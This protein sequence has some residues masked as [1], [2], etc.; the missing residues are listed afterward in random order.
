MTLLQQ[1]Q[2]LAPLASA[3]TAAPWHIVEDNDGVNAAYYI[4]PQAGGYT[5]SEGEYNDLAT[6]SDHSNAAYI[7]AARNLLTPEN[8][9][10]ISG[11]L[12]NMDSV[13]DTNR[14]LTNRLR[15]IQEILDSA[16]QDDT[17]TFLISEI[18]NPTK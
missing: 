15:E 5:D 13:M 1:L 12:G 18:L 16:I 10:M 9:T 14:V 7:A 8:L 11:L 3:A 6:T 4:T 17:M 2:Q